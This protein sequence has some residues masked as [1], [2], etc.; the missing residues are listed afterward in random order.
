MFP[1]SHKADDC[2][3]GGSNKTATECFV[4]G[5]RNRNSRIAFARLGYFA[6]IERQGHSLCLK[7][8]CCA[9]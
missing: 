5:M 1:V 3:G 9:A 2:L 8:V 6:K 7:H 4:D